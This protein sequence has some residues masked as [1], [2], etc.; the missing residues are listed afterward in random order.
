MVFGL[1]SDQDMNK[2]VWETFPSNIGCLKYD[3]IDHQKLPC[4]NNVI[5]LKWNKIFFE[6]NN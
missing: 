3:K 2:Q 6:D 5:I 1:D 4:H